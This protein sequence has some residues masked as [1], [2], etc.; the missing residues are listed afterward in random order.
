MNTVKFEIDKPTTAPPGYY[1]LIDNCIKELEGMPK[2]VKRDM[3]K[4]DFECKTKGE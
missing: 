1:W 4:W 2:E 3:E